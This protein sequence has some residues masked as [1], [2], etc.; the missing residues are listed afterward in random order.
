M[1]MDSNMLDILKRFLLMCIFFRLV[2]FPAEQPLEV[3]SCVCPS[4][5]SN[6]TT[7]DRVIKECDVVEF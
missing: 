2:R 7:A 1:F 6:S 5:F 4:A 3:A